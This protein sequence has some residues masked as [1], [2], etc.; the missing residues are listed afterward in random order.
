MI[1]KNT[2]VVVLLAVTG[3]ATNSNGQKVVDPNTLAAIQ[4]AARIT[5]A[6][7][8]TAAAVANMYTNNADVKTTEGAVALLCAAA[9]PG[10][11]V[12]AAS[13]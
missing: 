3:C 1:I 12:P 7:A 13:K 2:L 10:S 6:L 9:V 5:C 11:V 4:E 8:P